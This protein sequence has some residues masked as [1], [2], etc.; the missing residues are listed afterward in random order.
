MAGQQPILTTYPQIGKLLSEFPYIVSALSLETPETSRSYVYPKFVMATSGRKVDGILQRISTESMNQ[1]YIDRATVDSTSE[2][3][4][5]LLNTRNGRRI[6]QSDVDKAVIFIQE[7][8]GATG[9]VRM[10]T[11][12][13][14]TCLAVDFVNR[15]IIFFDPMMTAA[16]PPSSSVI[17]ALCRQIR[18]KLD[19]AMHL[20]HFPCFFAR[21][22]QRSNATS[23]LQHVTR[24]TK[25]FLN[26]GSIII[27]R[28][29]CPLIKY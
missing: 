13:H 26:S 12:L 29:N 27:N 5:N 19:T 15:T 25:E 9:R 17:Q 11:N 8:R 2:C 28:N 14:T 4:A 21:G 10:T 24:W 7:Y 22:P 18:K 1:T 16:S 6:E 20:P 3:M 23:C